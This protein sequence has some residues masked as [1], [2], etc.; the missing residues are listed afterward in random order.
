MHI[1]Y[2]DP[3]VFKVKPAALKTQCSPRIQEL[4]EPIT[5]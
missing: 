2:Y 1:V 4:A 5:H 3:E